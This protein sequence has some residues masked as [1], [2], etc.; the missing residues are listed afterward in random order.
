MPSA[1]GLARRLVPVQSP[2]LASSAR[3]LGKLIRR[4]GTAVQHALIRHREEIVERQL[5]QERIAW[6]AM[7]LF[8]A[9]CAL[10]RWDHERAR[11][12]RSHDP[13]ARFCVADS[14]RRA[15][16]CLRD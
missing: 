9:A 14:L 6:V 3:R 7:E 16:D 4:L 12:D 8:A 15:E 5:V 1:C 13:V 10:S 2:E 11:N